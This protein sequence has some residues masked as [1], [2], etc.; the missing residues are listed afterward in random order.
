MVAPLSS[1]LPIVD[2]ETGKPNTLLLRAWQNI[3]GISV[4]RITADREVI[5]YNGLG[6]A[7]PTTQDTTFTAVKTNT[8]AGVTWTLEDSN[9][10]ILTA[11]SY[12]SVTA[13]DTTVMT[14]TQFEAAIAVN[15]TIGV[16]VIASLTEGGTVY[17]DIVTLNKL[18]DGQTGTSGTNG[19]SIAELA[20]YQ[21]AASLPSTPT[22]GSYDFSTK[23]LTPPS[24]WSA[25]P[26]AGTNIL[27]MAKGTAFVAA[28]SGTATPSWAGV[29]K[30]AQMA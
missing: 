16:R 5:K 20:C 8:T 6:V 12:L 17:K 30:V 3:S 9:G 13:G 28:T 7:T 25:T 22:G 15:S 14:R 27:Y 11:A 21:R 1:Q 29:G 2:P 24:G 10:N 26:P 4:L 23:V 19:L 18:Q